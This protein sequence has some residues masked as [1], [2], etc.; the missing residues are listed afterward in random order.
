[1]KHAI[2]LDD[3]A[4]HMAGVRGTAL[5]FLDAARNN[6]FRERG[7][8]PAPAAGGK[9]SPRNLA[10]FYAT[11]PGQD[12]VQGEGRNSPFTAAILK[13]IETPGLELGDF[14]SRVRGDVLSGT[15]GK[16]VPWNHASI[17]GDFYF[18]R[19]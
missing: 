12:L 14:A 15:K 18:V 16:Q 8:L 5:I 19:P 9:P 13:N 10:L 7:R 4:A 1:M 6:P 3:V 11:S 17:V 2:D